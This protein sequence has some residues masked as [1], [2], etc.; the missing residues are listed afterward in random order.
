MWQGNARRY[1]I[2]IRWA[3][4]AKKCREKK[5]NFPR[6]VPREKI[7]T[8]ARRS[9]RSCKAPSVCECQPDRCVE[10]PICHRRLVGPCQYDSSRFKSHRESKFC[11]KAAAGDV[12]TAAEEEEPEPEI[13]PDPCWS[14]EIG[15]KVCICDENTARL[16]A[17]QDRVTEDGVRWIQCKSVNCKIWFHLS[18]LKLDPTK[19]AASLYTNWLCPSCYIVPQTQ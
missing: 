2:A 5:N 13:D 17:L 10:C 16:L 9:R 19:I 3:L 6:P 18:C 1:T 14:N 12:A 15:S 11:L 7:T 8:T 4:V